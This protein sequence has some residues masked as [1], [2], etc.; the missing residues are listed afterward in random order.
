M[1]GEK[2]GI[3]QSVIEVLLVSNGA[4]LLLFINRYLASSS[5]RY[6]FLAWN[7]FLACLPLVFAWQLRKGLLKRRWASWQNIALTVLWLA[8]LPN[9]FYLVSDFIHLRN[10]GEISMLYD[11]VMFM[12]FAWNGFVLGFLSVLIVHME[13][14]KRLSKRSVIIMLGIVFL[15]CSFA[16]YLGRY[17]A[18]NTWDI[19]VNPAGILF[20]LSDR[21]VKPSSYPNTFTTTSMFLVLLTTSY[22]TFFGLVR[23]LRGEPEQ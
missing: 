2:K 7:L 12:S 20:D 9:S 1:A 23:V 21:I 18:W 4:S 10:T 19:V 11:A 8:F 5:T 17:L 13:L 22:Y 14:L 3:A 6:W 15:L 16:I